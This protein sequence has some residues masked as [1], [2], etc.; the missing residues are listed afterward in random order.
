MN[1]QSW[2]QEG[3][4][5]KVGSIIISASVS[6]DVWLYEDT[7][8][9]IAVQY[10]ANEMSTEFVWFL[11]TGGTSTQTCRRRIFDP[12]RVANFHKKCQKTVNMKILTPKSV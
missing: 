9:H 4:F 7:L 3:F 2:L 10:V 5:G 6:T 1:E 12:T 11:S 8:I